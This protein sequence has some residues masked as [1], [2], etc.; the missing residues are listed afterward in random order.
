MCERRKVLGPS[1][2]VIV[3]ACA[4]FRLK[5]SLG[6]LYIVADVLGGFCLWYV[7]LEGLP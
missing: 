4:K 3:H 1:A 7:F 6:T 2:S 5:N